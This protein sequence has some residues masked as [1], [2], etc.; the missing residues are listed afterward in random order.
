MRQSHPVRSA[1][2]WLMLLAVVEFF[3]APILGQLSVA[4]GAVSTI[5]DRAEG[6]PVIAPSWLDRRN[7]QL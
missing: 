7:R 4:Q 1:L 5:L 6:E 3:S 2:F